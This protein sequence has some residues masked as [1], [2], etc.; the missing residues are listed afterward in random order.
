MKSIYKFTVDMVREV[1]EKTKEKRKNKETGKNEEIEVTK[2]VEK[3]IPYTVIVKEPTRRQLEEADMEYSIEISRCIKKGIL[4]KAMLAKKYSDTG[5]ILTEKDAERLV[6]LYGEL[7]ELESEAA[8]L[9]IITAGTEKS[10]MS[11]KAK[12]MNGKIALARREIV[13][14][15]SSYQSLFN[16]TADIK[17]QNRVILW[18]MTH[19]S[20]YQTSDM[21]KPEPVFQ[22]DDFEAKISDYYQKDEKD[23]KLFRLIQSKL[24]AITSYWY[25]SASPSTA[26]F[27]KLISELDGSDETEG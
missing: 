20:H 15:E 6:D 21:E 9:G 11:D 16:H 8:K 5:G 25:F 7:A 2:Q 17:S 1:E 27:D 23:D 26:E 3:K 14:L 18:Y 12:E 10:K 4:T 24:A 13:S 22:G 19:L